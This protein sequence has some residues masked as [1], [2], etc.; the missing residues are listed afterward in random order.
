[1]LAMFPFTFSMPIITKRTPRISIVIF[2]PIHHPLFLIATP[3]INAITKIVAAPPYNQ[4][5]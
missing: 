5:A 2:T 1:M 3:I 4:G